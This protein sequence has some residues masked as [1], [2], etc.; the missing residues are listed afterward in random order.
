LQAGVIPPR[1]CTE[2]S[3]SIRELFAS[4]DEGSDYAELSELEVSEDDDESYDP[5]VEPEGFFDKKKGK[6]DWVG[7]RVCKTFGEHGNF[8][9][10]VYT[11][12]DDEENAGY[13]LF[14]VHY[15]DDPDDGEG[16]WP[17][18]LN[19]YVCF[20]FIESHSCV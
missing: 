10:I 4:D 3:T 14:L 6:D 16:M 15:F 17:E 7:R 18:E 2:R 1:A 11:V 20:C 19:R 8:D 9:G 5:T 13:R 12:D